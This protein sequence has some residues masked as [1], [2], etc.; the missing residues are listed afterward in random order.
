[1][2]LPGGLAKRLV[3]VRY[4]SLVERCLH[5]EHGLLGRLED[6]VQAPKHRH[7]QDD[8]TVLPPNVQVTQDIVSDAPNEVRD[9]VKVCVHRGVCAHSSS[10][11]ICHSRPEVLLKKL[12]PPFRSR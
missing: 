10:P 11:A 2:R 9:P 3:L 12:T 5:I 7:W 8:V 1:E 4:P 6:G